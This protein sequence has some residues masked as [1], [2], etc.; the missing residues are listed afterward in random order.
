MSYCN[1]AVPHTHLDVLTYAYDPAQLPGLAPG[2]CVR[3]LLRGRRVRGLVIELLNQS[4][5]RRTIPI[6]DIIEPGLLDPQLLHL[7]SWVNS[8]YFGRMGE[9]LSFA[10]PL[11]VCGYGIRRPGL[12]AT[13][14]RET[15]AVSPVGPPWAVSGFGVWT[16]CQVSGREQVMVSFVSQVLQ[17]GSVVV[18]TPEQGLDRWASL[19]AT[20][21]GVEPVVFHSR[22][23]QS[24]RRQAWFELR[25]GTRHVVVGVRSAVFAPV[26]DLGGIVVL[27]EHDPVFKEE[28][29]P[30][31]HARDVAVYRGR[32]ARCPVLLIDPT[33][34]LETW[35]NVHTGVYQELRLDSY[36]VS[37]QESGSAW[38]TVIDMH[39]H[40]NEIIAPLLRR[41][42]D[43]GLTR[44]AVLLYV[45]RRG[46]AR[47]VACNDCGAALVCP[48]CSVPMVLEKTELRCPYC[49]RSDPA[50]EV[51]PSCRGSDFRFQSPGIELVSRE[52]SRLLPGAVVESVA[53]ES[54]RRL[55][56]GPGHVYVGTRSILGTDW[57]DRVSLVAVVSIDSELC[58][59]DFRAHERVFQVLSGLARRA[60]EHNAR[61]V[62]Q[63]RRPNEPAIQATLSGNTDS[64]LAA[65]LKSRAAA[66]FPPFCRLALLSFRSSVAE[67]AWERA[68]SIARALEDRRGVTVLGPVRAAKSGF[69]LLVK[70]PKEMRLD[71]LL[72]REQIE[73]SR[74]SVRIDVDPF[75]LVL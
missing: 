71:R 13:Q 73:A 4:P 18:L 23:R 26:S 27:D 38:R 16:Y 68:L 54:R 40:R 15:A 3:V 45:N 59:C 67:R 8:Y 7:L 64:F 70:L 35:H 1:V 65:E 36:P 19:L 74:V 25:T 5:V 14:V 72:T 30:A 33:P 57:P 49:G 50:P 2:D 39:R 46:L 60:T 63:T 69:R 29:Q 52:V 42:I 43:R 28:R 10:L 62:I 9:T 17:T 22:L 58:R 53:T 34:S 20:Q 21:L 11:G 66:L 75:D 51:C 32:L 61:F 44:G 41:E 37:R 6:E 31:F 24:E 12:S 48:G 55:E 47:Y 56:S